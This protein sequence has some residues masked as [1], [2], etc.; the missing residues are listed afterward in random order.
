MAIVKIHF[1]TTEKE[2]RKLRVGDEVLISGTMVTG[3]DAAHKWMVEK[4]PKEVAEVLRNGCIY[5]CGPIVKKEK[6]GEYS[7][8]AAGPTTSIREEPYTAD[9]FNHYKVRAAI[10]KGGMGAKTLEGCSKYGAVYLHAIGGL[11]AELGKRVKEV[12][13]VYKLEFG[14]PEAMWVLEVEDFPTVVTMD[15]HLKSLHTIIE[16]DSRKVRDALIGAGK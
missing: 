12:V 14:V 16:S 9:V 11:A 3:R 6:G 2:I 5:H 4:H 15:S 13:H 10:G 1:P 7:F 8:V